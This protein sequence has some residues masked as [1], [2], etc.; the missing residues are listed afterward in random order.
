MFELA[1]G[2]LVAL[3]AAGTMVVVNLWSAAL[4]AVV[5]WGTDLGELTETELNTIAEVLPTGLDRPIRLSVLP[6]QSEGW[7]GRPGL[8]LHRDGRQAYPRLEEVWPVT[9]SPSAGGGGTISAEV[10]DDGLRVESELVLTPRGVLRVRH[11][12]L[13]RGPGVLTVQQLDCLL[14]VPGQAREILDFTGR[15]PR[16]RSPQRS[17]FHNGTHLRENRRGRTGHDATG[18]LVAGEEGFGFR[19]GEVWGVH[20][21]WSGNHVHVAERQPEGLAVLGGGE[22]LGPGEMRLPTGESYTSPWVY[23][24]Y[25][26]DGLDGLSRRLHRELRARPEHPRSTRPL[27]LNTWEAVYFDQRLDRL[28]ALADV[29]GRIGVERFVLDDGWFLGR[30]DDT[31][32]LGD[33]F[34]DPAVWPDGLH[35]LVNHVR[36][37]GMEF[38]L[39][40]EPEMVSPRSRLATEH[41]DWVL[42]APDHWPLLARDQL[43]L[44]AAH[45]DAF[46]YLLDRLDA[47]VTEYQLAYLKWDHNR[48]LLEAVHDGRVGVH[49]QTA[50]TYRLM[51]QLRGRHPGLE[52]ESCSSG[53]ARIDYGVLAHTDRVWASDTNDAV[54]R[55]AI[56]RYTGLLLPPELIGAHVGPPVAHT[57]GRAAELPFRMSTALFG[58]AGIEWDVT[59]CDV[60]EIERLTEWIRLYKRLRPLLHTGDVVHADYPDPSAW[61]HGVVSAERD[62][63]VYAYAR[64]ATPVDTNPPRLRLVGLDATTR[65]EVRHCGELAPSFGHG[66]GVQPGWLTEPVIA[67]GAALGHAGLAPP[68]LHP[69]QAVVFELRAVTG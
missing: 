47:L 1:T 36:G 34:V 35:P 66:S 38:G 7:L 19:H 68:R 28:T 49:V 52:I 29:A 20:V 41:P 32:G 46:A 65:Y 43:V 50:A 2:P 17:A 24:S 55:Q 64:L 14:P 48:D 26:A 33:W 67:T 37:L 22:L 16:E 6:G 57:T 9:V 63:A 54:E 51:A 39:W 10:E 23:F 60:A 53:G 59:T 8:V 13:N 40:V 56:Q 5:Y 11:S 18:L 42:A 44:D 30:R 58:H 27:T 12:V 3:R 45:P 69:A 61:L 62:H 15:W 25:A 21:G 31:A 4:P